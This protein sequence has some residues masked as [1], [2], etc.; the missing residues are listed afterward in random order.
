[1]TGFTSDNVSTDI[2]YWRNQQ[3][4]TV[5]LVYDWLTNDKTSSAY[6]ALNRAVSS[7]VVSSNR[8]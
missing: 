8:V 6:V 7:L 5:S 4:K 1:M 3:P 2:S